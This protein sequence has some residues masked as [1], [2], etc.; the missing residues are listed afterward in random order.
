MANPRIQEA[1][2]KPTARHG[3]SSSQVEPGGS[4]FSYRV[5]VD[6]MRKGKRRTLYYPQSG[7]ALYTRG[8][9]VALLMK[10]IG[11]GYDPE[12]CWIEGPGERATSAD[13]LGTWPILPPSVPSR[14]GPT[15]PGR[16]E[17]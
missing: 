13:L 15:G 3:N 6:Y 10:L 4:S 9:A 11:I 12:A 5:F 8:E 7:H 14:P 16:L 1:A 17:T 2:R